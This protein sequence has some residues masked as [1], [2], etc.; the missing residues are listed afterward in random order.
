MRLSFSSRFG[1]FRSD[2]S[3]TRE[4][5]QL[6]DS[7]KNN[8]IMV[9]DVYNKLFKELTENSSYIDSEGL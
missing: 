3:I 1:F 2:D 5:K 4:K 8:Q 7:N 6:F 9:K